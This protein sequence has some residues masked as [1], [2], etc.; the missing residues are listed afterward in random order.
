MTLVESLVVDNI[1]EDNSLILVTIPM[2]GMSLP[3]D[4]LFTAADRV[5]DDLENQKALTLARQADIH[6]TRTIGR[7]FC[8]HPGKE[9]ETTLNRRSY[10]G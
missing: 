4:V 8:V 3:Q 2:T 1:K 10:E 5:P 6:G 9:A 7:P